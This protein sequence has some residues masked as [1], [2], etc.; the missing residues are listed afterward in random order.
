MAAIRH[1]EAIELEVQQE[2]ELA[3]QPVVDLSLQSV[4]PAPTQVLEVAR[5]SPAFPFTP[6]SQLSP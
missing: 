6:A 5:S 4:N 3:A 2:Q 1:L